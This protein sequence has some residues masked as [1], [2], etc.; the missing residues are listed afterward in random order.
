MK[1]RAF[2]LI[3]LLVV[4][5]IIS[6]L[7]AMVLPALSKAKASAK[8]TQCASNLR[9]FGLAV[10]MYLDEYGRY[11][12]YAPFVSTN[13]AWYFGLES[14]FCYPCPPAARHID[15]KQAKLYPYFRTLHGIE[16]CPSYDYTSPLWRQKFDQITDCYGLNLYLFTKSAAEIAQ[17]AR[18]VCFAD[19]ANVNI[20]DSPA[21]SSHPMI[22]EF[23]FV[24]ASQKLIHFRH[25]GRA[26]VLFCDGHVESLPMATGTLDTRLPREN[27]GMLNQPGN[28]SMFQ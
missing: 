3:E 9:Q 4:I 24:D 7:T 27:I 16:V 1:R 8:R 11:F 2:T 5:A 12:P 22:E 15:L 28:T 20:I 14:P 23:Y 18:I 10:A 13:R 6:V 25:N 17:P 26:N 19:A 21:S